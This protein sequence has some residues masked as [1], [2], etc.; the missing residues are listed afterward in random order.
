MRDDM[1]TPSR[2]WFEGTLCAFCS[3]RTSEGCKHPA[4]LEHYHGLPPSGAVSACPDFEQAD[5][6]QEP[7]QVLSVEEIA[8]RRAFLD[9]A[10]A[11]EQVEPFTALVIDMHLLLEM[12]QRVYGELLRLLGGIDV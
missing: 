3:Y 4:S 2:P 5:L 8:A 11:G 6:V 9:K 10:V 7:K 12:Q 1:T